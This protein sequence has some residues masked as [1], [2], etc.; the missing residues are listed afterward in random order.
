MIIEEFYRLKEDVKK[1]KYNSFEYIDYEDVQDYEVLQN[2]ENLILIYGEDTEQK[3][4]KVNWA[5]NHVD[6]ITEAVLG[7]GKDILISFIPLEWREQ[8]LRQGFTDYAM[9]REYWIDDITC[10]EGEFDYSL[11]KEDECE[12]AAFVTQSCRNQSRGFLGEN[13]EFFLEWISGR[14]SSAM[15]C[16]AK[17]SS[18]LVHKNDNRIVGVAC[19]TIYGY[20]GKKGPILWLREIAVHPE[21]QGKGIGRKLIRQALQYGKEREAK[22][23][24]LM[25]DDCNENAIG[26]YKSIGFVPNNDI[27]INMVS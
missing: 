4:K 25:A 3:Q 27:E 8:F 18:V 1:F 24:F 26:L 12:Q 13:K 19:V 21:F 15:N 17:N 23:S 16:N 11:L 6:Q 9:F 22:R 10:L 2:N 5:A 14:E 20:E 7:L